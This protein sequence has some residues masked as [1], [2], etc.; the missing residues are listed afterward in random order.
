MFFVEL[1]GGFD[2]HVAKTVSQRIL[3]WNKTHKQLTQEQIAKLEYI[4]K[5]TLAKDQ[6]HDEIY[7]I[8]QDFLHNFVVHNDK[9]VPMRF[10]VDDAKKVVY[11]GDEAGVAQALL[12]NAEK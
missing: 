11:F 3:T 12:L 4:L 10:Y 9:G 7:A 8:C 2:L 1:K 6:H 5:P